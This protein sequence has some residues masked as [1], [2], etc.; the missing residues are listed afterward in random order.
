MSERSFTPHPRCAGPCS[1]KRVGS[2]SFVKVI[3]TNMAVCGMSDVSLASLWAAV[4]LTA[5]L[6]E[7]RLGPEQEES[8]GTHEVMGLL[9]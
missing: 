4:S 3:K 5:P 1:K 8:L 2:A 6:G 9:Q 7:I